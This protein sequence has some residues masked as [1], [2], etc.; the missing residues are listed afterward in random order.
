MAHL[1]IIENNVAKPNV[2][3]LLISPFKE[4]WERD[5]SKFKEEAIKEFT[6][7]ELMTSKLKSNPYSGY[8]EE[9][10]HNKLKEVLKFDSSWKPDKLLQEAMVKIDEFQR[11]ASPTY[12]YYIDSLVTAERTRKFLKEIDLDERNPKTGGLLYKPADVIKGVTETEKIIQTL[13]S[14][15]KKVEEE[16]FETKRVRGNRTINEFEM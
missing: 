4:I 8:T 13:A 5:S 15:K 1:F 12:Q 6:Y 10:R 7:V 2:E 11:E 9:D 16:L 14:L 3:T